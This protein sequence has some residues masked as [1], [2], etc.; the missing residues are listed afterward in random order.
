MDAGDLIFYIGLFIGLIGLNQKLTI[1]VNNKITAL[2]ET[3]FSLSVTLM[4]VPWN[5]LKSIINQFRSSKEPYEIE[6][7]HSEKLEVSLMK[8]TELDE[9]EMANTFMFLL[10]PKLWRADA[11]LNQKIE[12][13]THVIFTSVFASCMVI[14]VLGLFFSILDEFIGFGKSISNVLLPFMGFAFLFNIIFL[15]GGIAISLIIITLLLPLFLID[16]LLYILCV[17]SGGFIAAL[18]V[19]ITVLSNLLG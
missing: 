2:R 19:L 12:I 6:P 18:G 17:P 15:F 10:L 9:T 4:S 14:G 1:K 16:K 5:V 8:I 11:E 3:S 7:D 13:T